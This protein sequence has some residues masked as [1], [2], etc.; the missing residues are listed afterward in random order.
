MSRYAQMATTGNLS[1]GALYYNFITRPEIFCT[2][3][4]TLNLV[5]NS[6]FN[7]LKDIGNVDCKYVYKDIF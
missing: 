1:N 7:V 3:N 2:Q 6:L 5:F 4:N